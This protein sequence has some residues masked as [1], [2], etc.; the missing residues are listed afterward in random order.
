MIYYPEPDSQV[1]D[2]VKVVLDLPHYAT[3]KELD[4]AKR[5]NTSHLAAKKDFITLKAEVDKLDFNTLVNVWTSLN[6]LKTKKH[7]VDVAKLKTIP[8]D[9]NKLSDI[10]DSE[11]VKNENWHNKDKIT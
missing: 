9:L 11:V 10:V 8:I 3:K 2:K 6:N 7:D 1:R 5:V 4:H